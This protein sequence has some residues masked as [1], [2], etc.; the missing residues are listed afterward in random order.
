MPIW[1]NQPPT[2]KDAHAHRIIRTPATKPLIAIITCTDLLGCATHFVSNRTVP[3][4]GQG[5]CSHCEAGHSWRWH[6]YVSAVNVNTHEH[7]IFEMTAQ[8]ADTFRNYAQAHATLRGCMFQATRPSGRPNG[9]VVIACKPT[10]EQR[11]RI[12]QPLN[13]RRIL[14]HIWNVQYTETSEFYS[15]AELANRLSVNDSERD[16]RYRS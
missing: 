9:R 6:G 11:Y 3:C 7:F 10:D 1:T 2:D 16:G 4:E 8:A 15:V 13:V 12:P 14:C 5:E